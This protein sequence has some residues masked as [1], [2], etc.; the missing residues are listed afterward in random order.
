MNVAPKII[1]LKGIIGGICRV[2]FFFEMN[3]RTV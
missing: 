1:Y 2:R 3:A